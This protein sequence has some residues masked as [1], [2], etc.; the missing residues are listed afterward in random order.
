M[1]AADGA[2]EEVRLEQTA[3][4][5]RTELSVIG[6]GEPVGLCGSGLLAAIREFLRLGLIRRDGRIRPAEE[7]PEG[8][9]RRALCRLWGGKPALGFTGTD[10]CLTQK[11]VRQVQL[12]KGAILSAFRTLL[13][14]T[15]LEMTDLERVL[16][17]GQFGSHLS[18]ASLTGCGLLPPELAERL[19]YVGN[20]SKV[21][22]GLALTSRSA[23][24]AMDE[25]S[26]RIE[27][28]ELA[29]F[30]GY[31]RLF[32]DSLKFPTFKTA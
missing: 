21:G 23:W 18:P 17:A 19:E 13:L 29:A 25:L 10:L 8:D 31:D 30:P 6:G 15:G 14:K 28:F 32:T 27:F 1:R 26:A 3:A 5:C 16:V 11:D 4:G 22:A 24:Q 9:P 2:I 20:T 12:A 7:L